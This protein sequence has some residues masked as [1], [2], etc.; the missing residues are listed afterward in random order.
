M[1]QI[2][3]RYLEGKATEAEQLQLLKWLRNKQNRFVFNSYSLGWKESLDVNQLPD[4]GQ[5]SWNQIQAVILEKSYKQWQHSR[6]VQSFF[7]YAAIFFFMVTLTGL[8]WYIIQ[9]KN[10][11]QLLYTRVLA[12]KG[13]ISKVELPDGSLVWLNSG[14]EI[15]YSSLF[16]DKNRNIQL[17]GEAYFNVSHNEQLPLLVSCGELKVKVLGTKFN[18][19]AYEENNQVDVVLEKGSVELLDAKI[20]SFDYRLKPGE[21]AMFNKTEQK[22]TVSNVNTVKF[23]SWKDGIINIYDQSLEQ[24]VKRLESR[25]NQKFRFSDNI[26]D[27]R[28]TFTIKNEPLDEIIQLMEKITPVKAIQED[29]VI[30]FEMDVNKMRKSM[31][32]H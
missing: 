8:G 22:M 12:E 29:D 24:V 20:K 10:P 27:Y 18:V 17:N 31:D 4:E 19:S 25:Y 26:K 32:K 6:K 30:V 2:I 11:N 1:K 16:A 15:T 7:K 5:K 13:H 28:Y 14:S 21:R 23:T 9:S 3:Y